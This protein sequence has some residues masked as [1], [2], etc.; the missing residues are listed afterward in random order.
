MVSGSV[1]I[2]CV[3]YICV[4]LFDVLR[5]SV[6]CNLKRFRFCENEL[7]SGIR[8]IW[9]GMICS[10]KMKMNSVLWFLKLIYVNVYVVIDVII[11]GMIV[12]GMVIVIEL[13]ND[14]RMVSCVVL[15]C[16]MLM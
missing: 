5:G 1:N 14:F 12:V 3:I 13:M 8:V 16:S 11:S 2:E 10:V 6:I 9:I 4:Y 7:S 15:D